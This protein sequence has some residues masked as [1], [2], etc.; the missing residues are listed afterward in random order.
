M[1]SHNDVHLKGIWTKSVK[2]QQ[3]KIYFLTDHEMKLSNVVAYPS[4]VEMLLEEMPFKE[5]GLDSNMKSECL[6]FKVNKDKIRHSEAKNIVKEGLPIQHSVRMKYIK[7]ALCVKSESPELKEENDNYNK[8]ISEVANKEVAE[9]TGYF[10][11]VT[12]GQV[13]QEGSMVLA[14]SN[15]ITPLLQHEEK[16]KSINYF[17][18]L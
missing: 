5:L 18:L 15:H 12:E 16:T 4:D 9:K 6:I 13:W 2:E 11:A 7:I 8:Y 10:W 3:G 14:G 17:D 1:D